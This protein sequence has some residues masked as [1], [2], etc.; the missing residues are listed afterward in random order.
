LREHLISAYLLGTTVSVPD[1]ADVGGDYQNVPTCSAVDQVGCV[2]S[3]ASFRS[4]APP[5]TD[6]LF[7][8]TR[9]ATTMAACVNPAA[10]GGG[11]APLTSYF[12]TASISPTMRPDLAAA[13]AT[14]FVKTTWLV[15]GECVD[16]NDISY[17]ELTVNG[18][19]AAPITD[20]H[21]DLTAPW[22]M[23]LIDAD[24]TMGDQ[25][26]MAAAQSEAWLTRN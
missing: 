13:V 5:P 24:V 17:L 18:G 8:R 2:V 19:A 23:H 10:P 9:D 7:G 21:G 12:T 14:P 15:A 20:V 16:R 25:L 26:T 3:Y 4:T 6:S 11:S 22:G 1:G